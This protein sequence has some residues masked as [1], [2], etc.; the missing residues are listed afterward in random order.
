MANGAVLAHHVLVLKHDA[1]PGTI[2]LGHIGAADE[3]D[4]L[5]GLD[6]AGARVHRIGPDPREIVDLECRD[7]A[8]ALDADL[9]LAAMVAGMNVGVEAL[10]PVGDEFDRTPQQLGQRVSR[11]LV[12]IN[13]NLDAEGAADVLADH[14]DLRFLQTEMKRRNILHH[15]RRLRALIDGQPR[16][17]GVPVCH[18]RARLQ[19]H[20]GVPPENELC[21]HHLVRFGKGLIDGARIVIALKG[22]IVAE[23]GM[24]HGCRRI[25]RGAHVR[26]G[27][28]F[29][30]IDRDKLRGV[31]GL[32]ATARHHGRDRFALPAHAINRDRALRRGFEALQMRE[33]ADPRRDDGREFAA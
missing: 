10:D 6:R 29:L 8:I 25:K 20:A 18:Y 16:F 4:D 5:I 12:G 15:M 27:V 7:G 22:Q 11:H 2:I 33:H 19:R 30:I 28:E 26:Y 31:L 9:S 3:I 17:R 13:V 14:A 24:D 32:S 21:L 1:G 23:R